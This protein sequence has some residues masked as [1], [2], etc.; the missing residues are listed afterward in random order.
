MESAHILLILQKTLK[1]IP[2]EV[3]MMILSDL[4]SLENHL[5]IAC[6][7]NKICSNETPVYSEEYWVNGRIVSYTALNG[8][9]IHKR[10]GE[11]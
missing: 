9:I 6:E 1:D 4:V 8:K 3:L 2:D 11:N 10:G 5:C 7:Y